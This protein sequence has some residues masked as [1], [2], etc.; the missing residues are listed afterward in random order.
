MNRREFLTAAGTVGVAPIVVGGSATGQASVADSSRPGVYW[1][2]V[3]TRLADP[4]LKNL[5]NGTLK[6][7]MPVEQAAGTDGGRSAIWRRSAGWWQA[8]RRGSSLL[9]TTR[10]RDGC[11]AEYADLAR[12]AIARAVD[13]A[14]P[15][16]LNFTRERQP[17]VDAAF[18]AQG[19][20]RAPRAL[21][22]ALGAA[23]IRQLVAAL[24]STRAITPVV[25]QL[26]A[27]FRDRR[28]RAGAPRCHLGPDA[29]RLRAASARAVV[30]GRRRLRRRPRVPLGL[31][32]QLRHPADAARRARRLPGRD[33]CME[34]ARELASNCAR[35]GM[36]PFSSGSS[37]RMARFRPSAG[38][39]P[40][41]SA[42][43]S[44][45]R[46]W[47]YA[48][49]CPRACRRRRCAAR[50]R[51]SSGGRS[52]RQGRSTQTAGCD[53]LLRSPAGRRRN[54]HLD[55]QPLSVHGRTAAPRACAGR[56]VL[57]GSAGALDVG[58]CLVRPAVPHR[59]RA[60]DLTFAPRLIRRDD[61]ECPS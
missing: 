9:P 21:R 57:V 38:P 23:T 3:M 50:S 54:L 46:R 26:A 52:R 43:S 27:V 59:P 15:D 32:Q 45:S 53:R 24:E 49:R 8:W 60:G 4:V 6:A 56:S 2:S 20:L 39:S 35:G 28:G 33:A 41:V 25:Q 37:P 1:V 51:R 17:L 29:R 18:L 40:I 44:C 19:I 61:S 42:R 48:R 12:R 11:V 47:R 16:F 30:Q 14:S 58:P 22:E 34:R 7:R 55:R 13:P 31:L 10:P 36:R 5:A